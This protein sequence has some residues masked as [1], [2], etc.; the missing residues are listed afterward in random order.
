M[1][2][3]EKL[4]EY[5][6]SRYSSIR[7]FTIEVD[8]PYS[9]VYVLFSRGIYGSSVGNVLK[10]CKA[11]RI[12]ADALLDGEI[13]PI[14]ELK[15]NPNRFEVK[16]ILEET[17]EILNHKGFVTLEGKPITKEDI[18]SIFDAIDVGVEI[19]KKKIK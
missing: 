15:I 5:I 12:S 10:I 13:V 7:E 16:E 14:R 19:A 6:L 9:T 4:K 18:N 1:T 17:K 11:L 2:I 3:E 8:I